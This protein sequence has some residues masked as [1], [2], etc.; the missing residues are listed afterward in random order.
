VQAQ[1]ALFQDKEKK[2]DKLTKME[3]DEKRDCVL[4]AQR[5]LN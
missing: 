3:R 1:N 2:K 4:T 5:A